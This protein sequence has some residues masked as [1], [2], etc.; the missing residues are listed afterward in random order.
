MDN[1]GSTQNASAA[2]ATNDSSDTN[3]GNNA[4]DNRSTGNIQVSNAKNNNSHDASDTNNT[5]NTNSTSNTSMDKGN[6][7]AENADTN[8]SDSQKYRIGLQMYSIK[9]Q[10]ERDLVKAMQ[11]IKDIGYDCIELVGYYTFKPDAIRRLAK[12]IGLKIHSVHMP[13]RIYDEQKIEKSFERSVKTVSETGCKY[14][15][16]PWMPIRESLKS[17]EMNFLHELL[18]KLVL[19]TKQQNLQL[20]MHNYSREFYKITTGNKQDQHEYLLDQLLAPFDEQQ[21][22]MELD[23]YAIYLAGIN[24][25]EIYERYQSRIPFIHLRNVTEGRK[26]CLLEQGEIDFAKHLRGMSNLEQ[27]I[28]YIEQQ[29][30]KEKAIEDAQKNFAYISQLLQ[31]DENASPNAAKANPAFMAATNNSTTP[32]VGTGYWQANPPTGKQR[33]F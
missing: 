25:F 27:K 28:I 3:A 1:M 26:D 32:S 15:V 21:I 6:H 17:Y 11:Q 10:A 5:N 24:P 4:N 9:H 22:Q 13:V 12:R 2:N 23:F 29:H 8:A 7:T 18:E 30:H 16:V 14:I 20:V 31:Q 19:C 33:S